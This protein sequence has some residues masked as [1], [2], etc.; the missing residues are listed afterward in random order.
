[1]NLQEAML[2]AF[3]AKLAIDIRRSSAETI[4]AIATM[5]AAGF[6]LE[7]EPFLERMIYCSKFFGL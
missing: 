7:S 3:D 2:A 4:N 5:V 1:M 6:K